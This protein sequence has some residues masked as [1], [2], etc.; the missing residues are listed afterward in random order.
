M[1]EQDEYDY[2]EEEEEADEPEL[3]SMVDGDPVLARSLSLGIVAMAPLLLAY[4]W[5]ISSG[6][7]LPRNTSELLIFRLFSLLG[8]HEDLARRLALLILVAVALGRCLRRELGLGPRVVRIW[9][10]GALVA[11][12]LGPLL[13]GLMRM[14]G[15]VLEPPQLG[16]VARAA[17]TPDLV[18]AARVCGAAAFE[19]L[20][21]RVGVYGAL[22]LIVRQLVLFLGLGPGL[23]RIFAEGVGLVGS[24]LAFAAFHLTA[25]VSW[26]GRGGEAFDLPVF[27]YRFLAGML[28]GLVLRLR[29]PGVA[30]WAHGLFNLALLLGAGPDV[31]S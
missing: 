13:I 15:D 30:A 8:P 16:G 29:G 6:S 14:A 3:E 28:L 24:S 4:E 22:V 17:S 23:G 5:A 1:R 2:E 9:G 11:L 26:L 31:F 19:E 27:T 18:R 20:V 21:F 7:G 25:F 12:V 10:E